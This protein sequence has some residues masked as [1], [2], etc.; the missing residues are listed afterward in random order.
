MKIRLL[1]LILLSLIAAP[2]G[3]ARSADD[4]AISYKITRDSYPGWYRLTATL[5]NRTGSA[6]EGTPVLSLHSRMGLTQE[7]HT[8][9]AVR[10]PSGTPTE[11][12]FIVGG[13]ANR[14]VSFALITPSGAINWPPTYVGTTDTHR[15][16]PLFPDTLLV[17][18]VPEAGYSSLLL[19]L[20]AYVISLPFL[21][22]LLHRH[23]QEE[24]IWFYLPGLAGMFVIGFAAWS[25]ARSENRV[26]SVEVTIFD[27]GEAFTHTRTAIYAGSGFDGTWTLP[28]DGAAS[29]HE[30]D[31]FGYAQFET[32]FHNDGRTIHYSLPSRTG[33]VIEAYGRSPITDTTPEELTDTYFIS[34]DLWPS[35]PFSLLMGQDM[36]GRTGTFLV[37]TRKPAKDSPFSAFGD[38][39]E[40]RIGIWKVG[41]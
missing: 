32:L 15:V 21:F 27:G 3:A 11:I 35:R 10:L 33:G 24:K 28:V 22:F 25:M 13:E 20:L 18:I 17:S 14:S 31:V 19:A 41:E 38:A 7:R 39:E 4:I 6:I 2:P 30:F 1:F 9:D 8:G 5:S 40:T 36:A 16:Y 37:G 29:H 23:K 34:R 12:D 26:R